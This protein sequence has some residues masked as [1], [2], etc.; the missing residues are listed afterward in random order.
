M[1]GGVEKDSRGE[2]QRK[3]KGLDRREPRQRWKRGD[4]SHA[5]PIPCTPTPRTMAVRK[6][7]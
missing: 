7:V 2:V 6:L 5:L 4:P 1:N 3:G